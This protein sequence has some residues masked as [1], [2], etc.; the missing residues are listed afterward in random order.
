MNESWEDQ[1]SRLEQTKGDSGTWDLSP[2]DRAAIAAALNRLEGLQKAEALLRAGMESQAELMDVLKQENRRLKAGDFTEEEFQNLCHRF[3]EDDACRFGAGCIEYNL[4][5]FGLDSALEWVDVGYEV[6]R[7]GQKSHVWSK[8]GDV[9]GYC[10]KLREENR[11]HRTARD[12][13]LEEVRQYAETLWR[14]YD[15]P[16]GPETPAQLACE[17]II[18]FVKDKLKDTQP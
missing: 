7:G 5:L 1:L 17:N 8:R 11:R 6:S 15:D 4:K 12:A 16:E 13:A 18:H 3:G 9:A 14:A 2:N 10:E